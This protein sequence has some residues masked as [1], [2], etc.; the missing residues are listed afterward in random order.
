[1]KTLKVLMM[2]FFLLAGA[3][4]YAQSNAKV[5]AVVNKAD[6]CHV[7]EANGERMMMEVFSAY[8]EQPQVIISMN[9]I[10]DDKS[11]AASKEK[12]EKLGVYNLVANEKRT[13]LILF[14]NPKTKKVISHISV[15]ESTE[16]I[17]KAFDK[18]LKKS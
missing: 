18:A 3:N 9:D 11:K 15:S 7:C 17:K 1:M 10:T 2:A 12:L 13:G 5:I 4:L 14:I 6:W 16:D 8:K